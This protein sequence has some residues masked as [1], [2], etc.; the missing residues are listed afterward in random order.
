M[1]RIQPSFF[2]LNPQFF[3]LRDGVSSLKKEQQKAP[4]AFSAKRA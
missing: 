2:H 3:L 4:F 1:K